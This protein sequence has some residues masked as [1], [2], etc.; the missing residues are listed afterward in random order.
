LEEALVIYRATYGE[1]HSHVAGAM[2]RLAELQSLEGEDD[3]AA[4]EFEKVIDMYTRLEGPDDWTVA[5]ARSAYGVC[6]TRLERYEEA[7]EHLL[8][9]HGVLAQSDLAPTA[10]I[11]A[12]RLRELYRGWG[13][14]EEAARWQGL[15]DEDTDRKPE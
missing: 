14:A 7:E 5:V 15:A 1:P 10:R 9:A 6:L 11:T 12:G 2:L 8:K 4:E 3:L 13:K